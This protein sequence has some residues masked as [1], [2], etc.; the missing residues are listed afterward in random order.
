MRSI[1]WLATISNRIRA[2]RI[3]RRLSRKFKGNRYSQPAGVVGSST[4]YALQSGDIRE[5]LWHTFDVAPQSHRDSR[6]F[7]R[8]AWSTADVAPATERLEDRTLLTLNPGD[9]AVVAFN[10]DGADNFAV[11]PLVDIPGGTVLWFTDGGVT[12]D[13]GSTFAPR[14]P[15]EF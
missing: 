6:R 10:S 2:S 12:E 11:A 4:S 15:I 8:Q 14:T 7:Q 13:N 1:N 3:R 5:S 9:V